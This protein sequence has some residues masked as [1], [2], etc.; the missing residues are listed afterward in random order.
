MKANAIDHTAI[1]VDEDHISI[2]GVVDQVH[3]DSEDRDPVLREVELNAMLELC[4]LLSRT[5]LIRIPAIIYGGILAE[6]DQ[7]SALVDEEQGE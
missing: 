3:A 1:Q 2:T 4:T 6:R 7:V 5:G